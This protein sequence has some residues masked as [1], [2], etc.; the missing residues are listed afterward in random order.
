MPNA[1][2]ASPLVSATAGS[3]FSKLALFSPEGNLVLTSTGAGRLQLWRAPTAQTRGYE[4]EQLVW[5]AGLECAPR[6]PAVGG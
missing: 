6:R 1:A 2:C 3:S 5:T 4:L